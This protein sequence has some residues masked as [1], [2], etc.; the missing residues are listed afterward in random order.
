MNG[1]RTENERRT[2]GERTENERR[3]NGERTEDKTENTQYLL[4]KKI[5]RVLMKKLMGING[6]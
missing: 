3:T 5:K 6:N 2:N 4:L 1:E